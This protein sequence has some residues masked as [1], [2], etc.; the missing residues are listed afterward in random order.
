MDGL[1]CVV[2]ETFG[3]I[4]ITSR[5]LMSAYQLWTQPVDATHASNRSAGV[6]KSSVFLGRSFNCRATALSFA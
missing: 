1:K 3:G 2:A 4:Q 5:T 6:S